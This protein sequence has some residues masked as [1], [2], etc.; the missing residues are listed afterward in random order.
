MSVMR[1]LL[2]A[3]T[4]SAVLAFPALVGDASAQDHTVYVVEPDG[5]VR[6]AKLKPGGMEAF[7]KM[8]PRRVHRRMVMVM[9]GGKVHMVADPKG[10]LY[11]QWLDMREAH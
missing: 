3:A 7:M 6:Q 2:I 5:T 8:K 11:N 9:A 1:K 10:T 4:T